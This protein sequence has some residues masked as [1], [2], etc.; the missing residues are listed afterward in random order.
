M[1]LLTTQTSQWPYKN[2]FTSLNRCKI[3]KPY[4]NCLLIQ[5]DKQ[6]HQLT[7]WTRVLMKKITV[8]EQIKKFSA[9]SETIK[10]LSVHNILLIK[11]IYIIKCKSKL[12][13]CSSVVIWNNYSNYK[14]TAAMITKWILFIHQ[15]LQPLILNFTVSPCILIH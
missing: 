8:T 15:K 5:K 3:F 10:F 14:F 7:P 4:I 11:M 9:F 1:P 6:T 12:A 13:Q 2:I